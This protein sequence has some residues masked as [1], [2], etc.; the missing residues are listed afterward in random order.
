MIQKIAPYPAQRQ[1]VPCDY[2]GPKS[3]QTGGDV[4]NATDIGW[5]LFTVVRLLSLS[6][7]GIYEVYSLYPSTGA[8]PYVT[9]VWYNFSTGI[10]VPPGTDL[11]GESVRLELFG[12]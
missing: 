9:F 7:S 5:D 4:L 12:A 8:V 11:S 1:T 2:F 10:Q 3:Y 6:I